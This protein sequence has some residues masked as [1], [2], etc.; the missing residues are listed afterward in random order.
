MAKPST[1][2]YDRLRELREARYSKRKPITAPIAGLRDAV[3][4]IPVKRRP[5]EKKK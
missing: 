5:K 2:K 1:E 3:A 4:S